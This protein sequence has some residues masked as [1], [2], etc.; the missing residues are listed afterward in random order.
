MSHASQGWFSPTCVKLLQEAHAAWA[1]SC[2]GNHQAMDRVQETMRVNSSGTFVWYIRNQKVASHVVIDLL[3]KEF[4]HKPGGSPMFMIPYR[5]QSRD[6]PF[7]ARWTKGLAS[8]VFTLVRDPLKAAHSAYLEVSRRNPSPNATASYRSMPC[9]SNAMGRYAAFLRAVRDHEPLGPELFHAFPQAL[10]LSAATH[11][12]KI[13]RLESPDEDAL[14]LKRETGVDLLKRLRPERTRGRDWTNSL[15]WA[16]CAAPM[17]LSDAR[18]E[19]VRLFCQLYRVDY[20]CGLGYDLPTAC[21]TVL[22]SR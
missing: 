4:G 1:P 20:A 17:Q 7:P 8:Y 21:A 14:S 11:Y 3:R 2:L 12:D 6:H 13:I 15:Q 22:G 9:S 18:E 16:G 10:K 5:L 19:A